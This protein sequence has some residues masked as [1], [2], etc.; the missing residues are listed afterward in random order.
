AVEVLWDFGDGTT[1]T[2][3]FPSHDYVGDG[4]FTLCLTAT[5]ESPDSS[6]CTITFCAVLSG[7]MVGGSGFMESE[8]GFTINVMGEGTS[9]GLTTPEPVSNLSLWP[10]PSSDQLNIQFNSLNSTVQSLEI[11]DITGKIIIQKQLNTH[12][13][14]VSETI[15][16][17]SLNSGV[18]LFKI[19]SANQVET[20]RFVVSK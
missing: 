13:G 6:S 14:K 17:S 4:P 19:S 12:G 8:D 2:D 10:N 16:V 1:S 15:D 5:F 11:M 7:D 20:K 3:L 9:V 18:Y